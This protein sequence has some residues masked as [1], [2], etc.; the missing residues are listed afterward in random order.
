MSLTSFLYDGFS[1][2]DGKTA[3]HRLANRIGRFR[4]THKKNTMLSKNCYISPNALIHPRNG[5]ITVGDNTSVAP[6]AIMQGD[7]SIGNNSSVQAYCNI[8]GYKGGEIKIGNFVRIAAYTVIIG[9]NHR[10]DDP[11]IP[12]CKQGMAPA[13]IVI[14]DNVWIGARVSV[15]AGVTIGEGSV[16]GAGAVVTKDIP[17]YSVAVGVPARVISSRKK[18][19]E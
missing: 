3:K 15:I 7:I 11:D 2:T 19:R 4:A 17:P 16:I 12:I 13:P 8:V 1:M 10:F 9:A 5:R 6:G 14:E 18:E